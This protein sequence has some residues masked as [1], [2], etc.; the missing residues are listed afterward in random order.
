MFVKDNSVSSI[1]DYF[2][3]RLSSQFTASELKLMFNELLMSRM[4]LSRAELM[5]ANDLRLSESDLLYFRSC[6]HRMKDNEPFQHVLG[7]TEFYGLE[8]IC[9]RRA[10]IPRPE[11]EE[12]VD[13]IVQD[14]RKED[15]RIL[16]ICTGT[17]CIA[18]ALKSVVRN[19]NVEG[20]DISDDALDLAKKNASQLD[21]DVL[22]KKM[23]VLSV[24]CLSFN[25]HKWDIIVSNPPYIPVSDKVQMHANVLDFE[26]GLALFV[27]NEDPLL[28]YRKIGKL[29]KESLSDDGSLYFE[30]HENLGEEVEELLKSIGFNSIAIRKDMQ[31]KDRMI[32]AQFA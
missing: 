21:L 13:W 26:P 25:S 11:T 1:K 30:I 23:D 6:V 17:G 2:F 19:G 14:N 5:L 3:D 10:L 12:L 32:K 24:N 7:S 20:V 29:A 31:G 8:I 28:F 15:A 4:K 18:L 9:D 16:D 27:S 22:F